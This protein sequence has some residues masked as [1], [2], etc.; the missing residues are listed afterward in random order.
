[1]IHYNVCK[2][3]YKNPDYVN[4]WVSIW[5]AFNDC[6]SKESWDK[7]LQSESLYLNFA[8]DF[9]I[10][11]DISEFIIS[12]FENNVCNDTKDEF[13]KLSYGL[14]EYGVKKTE[15]HV[16]LLECIQY[17]QK[18]LRGM[19]WVKLE[20]RITGAYIAVGQDY[21]LLIGTLIE[22]SI[23]GKNLYIYKH[24]DPWI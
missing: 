16:S 20:N 13:E 12:S 3:N 23:K 10:N 1:M 5:D 6:Y 8:I 24:T 2:F 18:S 15:D 19:I 4:D 21:N 22:P 7:Y 11:N 14:L 17:L 9:L